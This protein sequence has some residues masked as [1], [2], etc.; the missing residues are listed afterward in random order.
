MAVRSRS[1]ASSKSSSSAVRFQPDVDFDREPNVLHTASMGS[2]SSASKKRVS[3]SLAGDF[4]RAKTVVDPDHAA[5]GPSF[6]QRLTKKLR[7]T[8]YV[9][10]VMV[11]VVLLDAYCNAASIDARA[12]GNQTPQLWTVLSDVCLVLYSLELAL[13]FYLDGTAILRRGLIMMDVIVISAGY[14]EVMLDLVAPGNEYANLGVLSILRL[15]RVLRLLK[16]LRKVKSLR[17]LQ[18]LVKMMHTC[19]KALFWSFIFCFVVMTIWAMLIVEWIDPYV[20]DMVDEGLF[21]ECGVFCE[22]ATTS[23]MK[24]NLLLFKTV[25]AGDSWGQMAVPVIL[26]HPETAVIFVG[27]SLTLVFGVLNLIVAVV[28]DTFADARERD[29]LNLAEE[30]EQDVAA[31]RKF[32]QKIFE[33]I[34]EEGTGQLSLEQLVAGARQDAE[35]QSRLRIM[36]IDEMDLVELF[37]MID[38]DGSGTIEA[39]EFIKP[40]S[41]WVHDSKTAPRFIKYN[42]LRTMHQQEELQKQCDENFENLHTKIDRLTLSMDRLMAAVPATAASKSFSSHWVE[43]TSVI[44]GNGLMNLDIHD[45]VEQPHSSKR[46]ALKEGNASL[47]EALEATVLRLRGMVL[48]VTDQAL[49]YASAGMGELLREGLDSHFGHVSPDTKRQGQGRRSLRALSTRT[50]FDSIYSSHGM[51]NEPKLLDEPVPPVPVPKDLTE[52]TVPPALFTQDILG[53]QLDPHSSDKA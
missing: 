36:D 51:A 2:A 19:I 20:R 52:A 23:V 48:E 49:Q 46:V 10:N 17:E 5:H 30:L 9:N 24:A 26:M 21:E 22:T 35:F 32:L 7:K 39:S 18:K 44:E 43:H 8:N 42:M 14:V 31:D 6:C 41:R 47:E 45:M 33:R 27:S 28:V 15:A 13:Q 37:Q 34:D 4:I 11:F 40:L 29:I 38:T 50:T 25:I 53:L 3:H 1:E 12:A 16:L